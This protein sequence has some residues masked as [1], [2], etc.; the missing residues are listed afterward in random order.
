VIADRQKWLASAAELPDLTRSKRGEEVCPEPPK[1]VTIRNVYFESTPLELFEGITGENG[2]LTPE[3]L[4]LELR[5]L[6]VAQAWRSSV[7]PMQEPG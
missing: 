5:D 2:L 4:R 6:P 7:K 3:A 1:G